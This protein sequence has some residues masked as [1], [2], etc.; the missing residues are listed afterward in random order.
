[1]FALRNSVDEKYNRMFSRDQKSFD[2]TKATEI[3]QLLQTFETKYPQ[4]F[5]AL[6]ID[7]LKHIYM[8]NSYDISPYDN[9]T[10]HQDEF[11]RIAQKIQQKQ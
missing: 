11:Y 5:E 1:L 7:F 10:L 8:Y 3:A 2:E 9:K 6:A 4:E